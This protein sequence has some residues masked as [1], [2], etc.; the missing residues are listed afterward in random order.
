[1]HHPTVGTDH[2]TVQGMAVCQSTLAADGRAY[3]CLECGCQ[4]FKCSGGAGQDNAAAADDDGR[5]GCDQFFS[6]AFDVIQSSAGTHG[7]ESA[8]LRLCPYVRGVHLMIL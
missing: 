3:R 2:P 8:V 1:S 5:T 6:C 7:W 4:R